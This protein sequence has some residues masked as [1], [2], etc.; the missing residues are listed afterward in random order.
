MKCTRRLSLVIA[1]LL[2]LFQF[3]APVGNVRAADK[4]VLL[5]PGTPVFQ[6]TSPDDG[7]LV[8]NAVYGAAGYNIY[9][10]TNG[11]LVLMGNTKTTSY[12]LNNQTQGKHSYAVATLGTNVVSGPSAPVN[13]TITYPVMAAPLSL[14]DTIKNGNDITL[15]WGTS[16]YA[17]NYNIYQV[18]QGG[19]KKLLTTTAA[20]SYTI[21]NTAKGNYTFYVTAVNSLYGESKTAATLNVNLAYPVMAGPTKLTASVSNG[22]DI[23][24]QW[25]AATY[26]D[27]YKVYQV[28]GGQEIFKTSVTSTSTVF[29]NSPAGNYVFKVYSVSSR[30]GTSANGSTVALTVAPITMAPPGS[31]TGTLQNVNDVVLTWG[32]SSY[33]TGYKVYQINGSQMVLMGTTTSTTITYKNQPNGDYTY[34]VSAY[35][36]RFGES[37]AGTPVTITVSPVTMAPP[38][39]VTAALSNMND[40]NLSWDAAANADSYK[41]YQ[42]ING[43][44]QLK[45]TVNSNKVS[46][47]NMPAGDYIYEITSYSSRFGESDTGSTAAVTIAPVTMAAPA[48]FA[49]QI[50]NGNDISLTWDSAPNA[51]NYRVYQII[52]G[53]KV[54]KSTVSSNSTTFTNTAAGDYSFQ[55]YSYNSRFGESAN[56]SS[57]SFTLVFPNMAAPGNLVQKITTPSAFTLSWDAAPYATTYNV[58]Q[59]VN[60]KKTLVKTATTTSVSFSNMKPGQYSYE[61]HS[62]STRFGESAAGSTISVLLNGQTIGAPTNLNYSISNGNDIKLTWSPAQNAKSYKI[63]KIIGGNKA[64]Q[65]TVTTASVTYTNQPAGNYDYVVDSYDSLLG[66][67]STG[68]E[69]KFTLVFP[70]M[71]PPAGL[72]GSIQNLSD[73]VLKWNSVPYANSYNVYEVVNGKAVLVQTVNN[74]TATLSK[75]TAGTHSYVIHSVSSRFGESQAGSTAANFT[76]TYPA[77]FQAPAN[78]TAEVVNGNDITLKWNAAKYATSYN[79]YQIVNGKKTFMESVKALSATLTNL[80]GGNYTYDVETVSDRFGESADGNLTNIT[81]KFPVMQAPAG[82][83]DT[84]INGNDIDL[85]WQAATYATSYKV[86]LVVNGNRTLVKEVPNTSIIFTNMPEGDY[87]YVVDS[88]SDRFGESAAESTVNFHLSWPVLQSPVLQ[89]TIF[90]INNVTFSWNSVAWADGYRLYEVNGNTKALLYD[91][92]DL[93]Y[94]DYNLTQGTH[95]YQVIAY[96]TL[97]GESSPS[98]SAAENIV[99]P[100]IQAP[101]ASI[102]V[103][104]PSSCTISWNSISYVNGYNVYEIV[105]GKPVLLVKNLNDSS[106]TISNLSYVNHL[107]YVTSFS[108]SFGESVPSNTVQTDITPPVTTATV[109]SN[110]ADG[111]QTVTLAASDDLSGVAHTYYA[112]NSSVYT[113]GTMF[114]LVQ[115][116]VYQVSY[117]SVDKAGNIEK[118]KT[119]EVTVN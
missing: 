11:K 58:Y 43:Q 23:N 61:I 14:T 30:F 109:V 8:W 107:Y 15:S 47:T 70:T 84:I 117:Y 73:I 103:N 67:S 59:T 41:V 87:N 118:S 51:T 83:T 101:T 114:T 99:Y 112:V 104:S 50:K 44:K 110:G 85:S 92:K 52:G 94:S 113:E 66:E 108:N 64:L 80:P 48:N 12:A 37:A 65:S 55:V 102:V 71:V 5:P 96:N 25:Q 36:D 98:N 31:V 116:G 95:T 4:N 63:Y 68:A 39:H 78:V 93:N 91:G 100:I 72:T 105:N 45:S 57:L 29:K 33:A 106:Y 81:V 34:A 20:K 54:L 19:A 16:Q 2:V 88:Y 111:S 60:G 77:D 90:D 21:A 75:V 7:N 53:K 89:G 26:A 13:V 40:I 27:S 42:I 10:I 62:F 69:L 97:F 6:A 115:S 82:F 3:A 38:N 22:N 28:I 74:T 24:L 49:Y 17:D 86:Y 9:Q 35:S 56:G 18:Y 79:I 46:F 32:N 119:I 1:L 76:V